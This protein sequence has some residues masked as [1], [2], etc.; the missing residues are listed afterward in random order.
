MTG[1]SLFILG[2]LLVSFFAD[3]RRTLAGLKK[4]ARMFLNVMPTLLTVMV[5]MALALYLIP[6]PVIERLLGEGSGVEGFLLAG[7]IGSIV[8]M[9]AFIAYPLC[10]TLIDQGAG[11]PVIALFITAL[12]MVGVVTLPMESK[13]FGLRAAIL[14]NVLS[15]VGAVLVAIL[16]GL[17]Y[18]SS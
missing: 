4:G 14:R 2:G 3:R 8:L 13:F 5:L 11:I 17:S 16:M 9:P 18:G 15:L 10:S 6:G 12:M 7:G 1:F